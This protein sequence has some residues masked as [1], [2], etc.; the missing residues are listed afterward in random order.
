VASC[1]S[2][3]H[4]CAWA[5]KGSSLAFVRAIRE[6]AASRP[7]LAFG[8]CRQLRACERRT[9]SVISRFTFEKQSGSPVRIRTYDPF[10]YSLGVKCFVFSRD[11]LLTG[12]TRKMRKL[13][14]RTQN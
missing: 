2:C 7:V 12:C 6:I 5:C 9:S 1:C 10:V 4:S 3:R 8:D 11:Y 14:S 13:C